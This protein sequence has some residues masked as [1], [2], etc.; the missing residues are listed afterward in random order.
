M[1]VSDISNIGQSALGSLQAKM[2]M[3][4][5]EGFVPSRMRRSS[6]QMTGWTDKK[7]RSQTRQSPEKNPMSHSES[8]TSIAVRALRCVMQS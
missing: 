4:Q 5:A 2:A 3:L 8:A 1:H 6:I 7:L